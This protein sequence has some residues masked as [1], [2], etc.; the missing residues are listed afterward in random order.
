MEANL[1]AYA[2]WKIKVDARG[3]GHYNSRGFEPRLSVQTS[4]GNG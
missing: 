4:D 3:V 2:K 1:V